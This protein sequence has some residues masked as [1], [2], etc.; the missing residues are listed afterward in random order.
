MEAVASTF[1]KIL[2]SIPALFSS[3]FADKLPKNAICGDYVLDGVY[4][5]VIPSNRLSLA[6]IKDILSKIVPTIEDNGKI[7]FP[8]SSISI[9]LRFFRNDIEISHPIYENNCYIG[10]ISSEDAITF[11]KNFSCIISCNS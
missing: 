6:E 7:I 2:V 8:E 9:F 1:H 3:H 4:Y 10:N 11:K 5:C